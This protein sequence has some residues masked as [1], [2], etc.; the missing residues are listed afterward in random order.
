MADRQ[1][2]NGQRLNIIAEI[3][4]T[5]DGSFGLAQKLTEGAAAAGANVVKFQWHIAAEETLK[6]A[7]NPPY[8]SGEGRFDY[9]S[10]TEFSI[11]QFKELADLC[12]SL[13]VT[14]CVSVFSEKSLASAVEAGFQIIKIPSGEITNLPLV[15]ALSVTGL[16]V[17]MSSGMSSWEELDEAEAVFDSDAQLAIVQCTSKYPTPAQSVGLNVLS[18]I[19]SRYCRPTGI[20]DHT[21]SGASCVAAVALGACVIEKHFTL[22]RGLYGP[23][24]RFSLEPKEFEKLSED[25]NFV[26]EA[27]ENPVDKND[28]SGVSDMKRVFQKSI[29]TTANIR[30]GEVF[31]RENIG[32]KKPGTGMPAKLYS[33]VLGKVASVDVGCDQLLQPDQFEG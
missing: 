18:D 20:S 29:V 5:H 23:D 8:F 24:A 28:L 31:S 11:S 16:P 27:L 7:P 19:D 10:R 3:G 17:I 32:I 14:P 1:S 33:Q 2:F 15:E 12:V 21:M 6:S 25:L 26:I 13:D 30:A 9:F 22:S 4:M